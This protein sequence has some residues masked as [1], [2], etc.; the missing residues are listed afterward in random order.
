MPRYGTPGSRDPE[1]FLGQWARD[2]PL[3]V[4]MEIPDSGIYP[5]IEAEEALETK[6]DMAS[7]GIEKL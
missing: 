3:G 7:S 5:R 2:V 1:Q 6:M 4:D